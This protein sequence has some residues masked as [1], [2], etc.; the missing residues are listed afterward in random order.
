MEKLNI[1][2]F[3]NLI[4]TTMLLNYC[5]FD[6]FNVPIKD[7]TY[8]KIALFLLS[9]ALPVMIFIYNALTK[10]VTDKDDS[11]STCDEDEDYEYKKLTT[12]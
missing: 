11:D 6:A 4:F 5:C 3:H 12:V 1:V 10:K 7:T 2:V 9:Q 8:H